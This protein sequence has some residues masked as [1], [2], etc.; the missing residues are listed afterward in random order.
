MNKTL[1]E[2]GENL[3]EDGNRIVLGR[4]DR[5]QVDSFSAGLQKVNS[6]I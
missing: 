6:C 3:L 5:A 4:V 1:L 2:V